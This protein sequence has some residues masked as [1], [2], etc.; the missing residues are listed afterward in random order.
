VDSAIGRVYDD[1]ASSAIV[2]VTSQFPGVVATNPAPTFD[3]TVQSGSG[4]GTVTPSGSPSLPFVVTV[5]ITA[6]GT[7]AGS[8]V[9][10]SWSLDGVSFNPETGSSSVNVG[11]SGI[12]LTLADA[13]GSPAFVLGTLYF[14]RTPGTDVIS[15]GRDD[16]T[17]AELGARSRGIIP[18]IGFPKDAN[19]IILPLSPTENGYEALVRSMSDQI[20]TVLVSISATIDNRIDIIIAGQ[21]AVLPSSVIASV[22]LGLDA[23]GMLTDDP[24]VQSPTPREINIKGEPAV[25]NVT[26]IHVKAAQLVAAQLSLQNAFASYFGSTDMSSPLGVNGKIKR[27][28]LVSLI[29]DTAGVTETDAD[30]TLQI[31]YDDGSYAGTDL[32]LPISAGS[33]ELA[34]WSGEDVALLFNWIPV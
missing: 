17:P 13:G 15:L 32:Q 6:S 33:F 20:V 30:T 9:R 23:L 18:L 29:S 12:T 19:G 24:L 11:G 1:A 26:S 25:S 21:G 34:D 5:K 7:V 22:Q 27:A 28:R 3:T 14:I 4:V 2:L 10:W 8:T 16:E 31:G